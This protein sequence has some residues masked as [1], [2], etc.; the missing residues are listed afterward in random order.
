M[1]KKFALASAVML[2]LTIGCQK[3]TTTSPSGSLPPQ[4]VSLYLTDNPALFDNVFIDITS[5]RV[6]VDT[7]A[8][9]NTEDHH[10]DNEE[11][12]S[13]DMHN[14]HDSTIQEHEGSDD[15]CRTWITLAIQPGV[16][17]LLTLRNGIDTLLAQGV[18]IPG[19]KIDRIQVTLGDNNSVVKDSVSFPLSLHEHTI[20]IL[21]HDGDFDEFM[22]DHSQLWIDFDIASSIFSVDG[23]YY[24]KPVIRLFNL[25]ETGELDGQIFPENVSATVTVYNHTDTASALP[26]DNGAFRIRGLKTGTYTVFVKSLTQGYFDMTIDNVVISG[27]DN[28]ELEIHLR[29]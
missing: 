6:E 12:D 22:P 27:G 3:S 20:T 11:H 8:A 21:V 9:D 19:G 2:I 1:K 16:Y 5:I 18:D 24:L 15:S 23:A 28:K 17:D 14:D 29:K 7:C 13:T 25:K 4:S 10:N 26:D